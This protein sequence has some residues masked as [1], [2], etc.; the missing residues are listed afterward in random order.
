M[1]I[2]QSGQVR[3]HLGDAPVTL[4]LSLAALMQIEQAL[5]ISGLE[6]LSMRFRALSASDLSEVLTALLIAGGHEDAQALAQAAA[7]T[8]AAKAVLACFQANLT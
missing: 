3:A 7:P 8:D 6:A 1:T 5:E 4:R 2:S